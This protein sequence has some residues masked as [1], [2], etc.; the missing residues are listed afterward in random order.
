MA[1]ASDSGPIVSICLPCRNTY[2]YLQECLDSIQLQE[3]VTWE[4]I[5]CDGFSTDGSWELLQTFCNSLP[6]A[7]FFQSSSSLY[8]AWNECI[9]L[10][11][12]RYIYIATS[13]DA[14]APRALALMSKALASNPGFGLCKIRLVYIDAQSQPL[15][16]PDQWEKGR[17]THYLPEFCSRTTRR[18]APHDG[19]LMAAFHTVYE[20]INQLLIC[21]EVF[22]QIGL[23]D[24]RF[25]AV[26]DFEWGMRA[27]LTQNC[28]FIPEATAYWRRHPG[29][30]THA[31]FTPQERLKAL[32]MMRTAYMRA[33]RLSPDSLPVN[34]LTAMEDIVYDD[35][36][37][38]RTPFSRG[39]L[40]AWH[41]YATEMFRRP[42]LVFR[43]LRR[44]ARAS[45]TTTFDFT[46]KQHRISAVMRRFGVPLPIFEP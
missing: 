30:A 19:V 2:P 36:I 18:L 23:F 17:L 33:S 7:I 14:L 45:V 20:S 37:S 35:Y 32:A 29:Q 13:D 31:A 12:G 15:N 39:Q 8:E 21:R 5:V 4:L 46:A 26:G 44:L 1:S 25:G 16:Q 28:I 41:F 34:L 38:S 22:D 43:H 6:R 10:A 24:P 27:G 11:Q 40:R 3:G 9:Q 42:L